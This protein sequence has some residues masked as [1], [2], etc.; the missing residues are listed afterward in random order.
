MKNL[1]S[2]EKSA[3]KCDVAFPVIHLSN[4]C[5]YSWSINFAMMNYEYVLYGE[6]LLSNCVSEI[7]IKDLIVLLVDLYA[8]S[9]LQMAYHRL[10]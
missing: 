10:M 3:G 6:L 1:P 2:W 5:C 8:I 4:E 7:E 9:N